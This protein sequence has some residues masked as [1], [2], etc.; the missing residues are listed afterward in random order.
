MAFKSS[1]DNSVPLSI[2]TT[3][4]VIELEFDSGILVGAEEGQRRS[5]PRAF[6]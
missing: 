5:N 6:G 2:G 3:E 1:S 4:F